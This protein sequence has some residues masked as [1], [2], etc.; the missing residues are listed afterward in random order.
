LQVNN[1][2]ALVKAS[3]PTANTAVSRQRFWYILFGWGRIF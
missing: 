1:V 2:C 3:V